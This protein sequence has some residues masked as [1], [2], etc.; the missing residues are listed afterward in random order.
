MTDYPPR[1]NGKNE[2]FPTQEEPVNISRRRLLLATAGVTAGALVLGFGF[3][4]KQA[5]A[6]GSPATLAPGT[7]VPAFLEIRPDNVIRFQCPFAEGGQGIF[8]AMAQIVGEELDADPSTFLVENAPAGADYLIME[9]GIRSTGGS[10]SVRSSYFTMRRLGALARQMLLQAA[11]EVL[12]VPVAS[13]KTEPGK[14]IH[15]ASGRSLPYG[16]LAARALDMP[17]PD[18]ASVKLKHP[19]DFRWIGKPVKRL[20][21]YE[22]STGKAVYTI[23]CSVEGMLHAAVQHAPRLGLK[24]GTIRNEA[25]VQSMKGI[26]SVHKLPGAVAVVAERWWNAKQA[27]E[28]LQID[29][30]EPDESE[31]FRYMPADFS[32]AAF[33]EELANAQGEGEDV[34]VKG[35]FAQAMK[36]AKTTLTA[37]YH[38]QHLNHAQLEPPTA[39]A[40]FNDDGT[41]EL[42]IPNQEPELFQ[43]DVAA[44]TGL[45]ISKVFIHSPLMGGFFG[46]HFNY[47][48]SAMA[49]PQ[50]IQLARA[51]GRPVKLI[52]SREEEFLRDTHRPMAAVRFSAG[53][54]AEGYP[55]AIQAISTCEGAAEGIA[56][57]KDDKIDETSVEGLAGKA[58]AIPNV[59]IAQ[60]YKKGPVMVGYWRS[61]GNSMNDFLYES[62]LDE[63]ADKGGKDPFELRMRLLK[64]NS[65]LTTLLRAVEE[66]SGGW[67]AGPY[68]AADGSRRARGV[69]M[70][71]PFGTQA[72]AIAEVSIENGQ[73]RVHQI[74]EAIDPGNIVNPAIIEAQVNSAVALGLSQV[75]IEESLYEKGK[76]VARNYDL[77]PILPPSRMA[78]VHVR[79][80]E[81]GA[82]MGGIGEPPLPAIPPAVANAVARLTGKRVRSMPLSRHDFT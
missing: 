59:R 50:A 78:R 40:R 2:K 48:H 3:P 77:Y 42:W 58:Y 23:D 20:D 12:Q 9:G 65:R 18:V 51:V 64:G 61:V 56:G 75:L 80:V 52:W 72:A 81:S 4:V 15:E 28:A 53:L 16:Q 44:L 55:I 62:F 19:S 67:K 30:L 57:K 11:A 21:V 26:H 74:W 49:Y 13:L 70:A 66:L 22:K 32:S 35:H 43:A 17:V 8:T 5:R 36:E 31:K 39:L 34:E 71:S 47:D 63:I 25:Q 24:V 33:V 45:D 6:K 76:P 69:A 14:V 41:L 79:I 10:E 46:R 37:Q 82:K 73:V 54:D 1:Q 7:R 29:W 60:L 27:A 68:T 38:S